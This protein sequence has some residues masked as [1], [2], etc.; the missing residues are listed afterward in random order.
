M[1]W[2]LGSRVSENLGVWGRVAG[3]SWILGLRFGI[4]IHRPLK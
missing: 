3:Q 1:V 2:G 4:E